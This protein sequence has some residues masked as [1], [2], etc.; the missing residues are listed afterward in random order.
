MAIP[1]VKRSDGEDREVIMPTMYKIYATVL[2]EK[3][4]EKVEKKGLISLNQTGFRKGM[5]TLDNVYVF[6]YLAINRQIK[7]KG[8]KMVALF[9]DLKAIFDS[10]D[11]MK[12]MDV[13]KEKGVREELIKR[14]KY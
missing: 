4:R 11:T 8:G 13:L 3:L 10:M 2:G 12:L 6:N 1:I 9:M 14:R 7:I 5:E